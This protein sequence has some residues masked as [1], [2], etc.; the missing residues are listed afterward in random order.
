MKKENHMSDLNQLLLKHTRLRAKIFYQGQNCGHWRFPP[1]VKNQAVFHLI[2]RGSC[3]IAL[4]GE[5]PPYIL[6]EGDLFFITR[7][8]EHVIQSIDFEYGKIE[9]HQEFSLA[10]GLSPDATG[11][12]CG[13][14]EFDEKVRNPLLEALPSSVVVR[15]DFH[16]DPNWMKHLISLLIAESDHDSVGSNIL[17]ERLV[18]TFFTHVVR[19]HLSSAS[20]KTGVFAAYSDQALRKVLEAM[21]KAPEHPWSLEDFSTIANLSRTAF[22]ERFTQTL[23]ETPMT[24]LMHI[25]LEMAYRF[26]KEDDRK[27]LDVALSCGYQSEASFCKAFKRLYNVTPGDVRRGL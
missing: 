19:C 5:Q 27:V 15:A 7:G 23:N 18:D 22:I 26:L 8:V 10:G 13:T 4:A 1:I 2:M 20:V 9:S 14:F 6:Q 16:S 11:I 25:R 24:Y 17:V 3:R 12:L 21:H